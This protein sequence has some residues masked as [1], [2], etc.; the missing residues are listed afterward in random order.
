MIEFKIETQK[1]RKIES[2]TARLEA[3]QLEAEQLEAERLE[4]EQNSASEI[5]IKSDISI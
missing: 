5:P 2:E 3:E 4:S 1:E